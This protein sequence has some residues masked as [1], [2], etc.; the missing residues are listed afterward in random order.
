[1]ETNGLS[2]KQTGEN[3]FFHPNKHDKAEIDY[4]L[5]NERG[6][7]LV[8]SVKVQTS[9]ALITSDHI[10]VVSTLSIR[11]GKFQPAVETIRCKPKWDKCNKQVY[12]Q[13]IIKTNLQPFSTFHVQSTSKKDILQ[14][15][16]HLN[17][18]LNQATSDSIP[19]HRSE[20]KTRKLRQRSLSERIL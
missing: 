3:T 4:N 12:E 20:I 10:S 8:T 19:R 7:E 11:T 1:M 13:L 16:S 18:V 6:K 14:P 9:F 2:S 17:A 5:Y 15:L